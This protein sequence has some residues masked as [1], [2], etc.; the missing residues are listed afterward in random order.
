[1]GGILDE[2]CSMS[3][4]A[5]VVSGQR[6]S[7]RLVFLSEYSPAVSLARQS[8]A[9]FA[10]SP[11]NSSA[12]G[13]GVKVV[14]GRLSAQ[15]MGYIRAELPELACEP[16]TP[17]DGNHRLLQSSIDLVSCSLTPPSKF[18]TAQSALKPPESSLAAG[19]PLGWI[20]RA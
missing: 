14:D 9:E 17:G 2:L 19:I 4:D 5:C 15:P 7:G 11:G 3:S 10:F 18:R 16:A 20:T 13:G 1:M 8:P 12:F 6:G